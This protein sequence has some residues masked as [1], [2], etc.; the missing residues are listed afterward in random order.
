MAQNFLTM[1]SYP[2]IAAKPNRKS[3]GTRIA[4]ALSAE[5]DTRLVGKTPSVAKPIISDYAVPDYVF[6][7]TRNE[8]CWCYDVPGLTA[9]SVANSFAGDFRGATLIARDV[10]VFANH[11]DF[12]VGTMVRFLNADNEL[13]SYEMTTRTRIG[14]TD[15]MIGKLESDV[16]AS[17]AHAKVF[18]STDYSA[19]TLAAFTSRPAALRVDRLRNALTGDFVIGGTTATFDTPV[20]AARLDFYEHLANGDSG[21]PAA[22]IVGDDLVL[23]CPWYGPENAAGYGDSVHYYRDE[24]NAA[25]TALGS[26]HQLTEVTLSL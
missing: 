23:M 21:N 2:A 19:L 3:R 26:T 15:L 6:E 25:M 24:I 12:P 1:P 8:D 13:L 7:G 18:N 22:F 20:N 14:S 11:Y 17:I 10:I 16:D 4:D 9:I 5:V